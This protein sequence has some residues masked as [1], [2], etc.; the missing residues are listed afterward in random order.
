LGLK[1]S[2][3]FELEKRCLE[4]KKQLEEKEEKELRIKE[5][6]KEFQKEF[7]KKRV[8]NKTISK[9][10]SSVTKIKKNQSKQFETFLSTKREEIDGEELDN[11]SNIMNCFGEHVM[12]TE[13][14]KE[15]KKTQEKFE[16]LLKEF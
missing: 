11:I 4:L 10:S 15:D 16:F 9:F 12:M 5:L 7:Q 2:Y 14:T 8:E 6:K 3:F 13:K 1:D